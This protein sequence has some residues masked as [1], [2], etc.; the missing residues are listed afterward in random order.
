MKQKY[1]LPAGSCMIFLATSDGYCIWS[2]MANCFPTVLHYLDSR[3][4]DMI[5]LAVI[6]VYA[7][8]NSILIYAYELNKAA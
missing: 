8:I 7:A 3:I 4:Q 5:F 2:A 6:L 1:L